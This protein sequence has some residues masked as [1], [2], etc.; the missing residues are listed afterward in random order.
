MKVL[1]SLL[2]ALV[3]GIATLSSAQARDSVSLA[4]NIG[5]PGYYAYPAVTYY[6]APPVVYYPTRRVYYAE[7][8]AYQY[9]PATVYGSGYYYSGHRHHRYHRGHGH[10]HD[11]HRR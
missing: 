7:P 1:R 3:I 9:Y 10:H 6:A 8:Y 5:G 2:V 11:G 4:I